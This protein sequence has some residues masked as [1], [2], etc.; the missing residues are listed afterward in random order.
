MTSGNYVYPYD[1]AFYEKYNNSGKINL[2][3]DYDGH[4]EA[5]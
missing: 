5:V 1:K 2:Y 4:G 3:V